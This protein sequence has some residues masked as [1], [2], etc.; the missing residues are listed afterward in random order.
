[1]AT[2]QKL[3]LWA[4][5]DRFLSARD[6]IKSQSSM[7]S[8][9]RFFKCFFATQSSPPVRQR[10]AASLPHFQEYCRPNQVEDSK[11]HILV[12]VLPVKEVVRDTDEG[13]G[14]QGKCE[15]F[16]K[17][18]VERQT[19]TKVM[20]YVIYIMEDTSRT[21]AFNI[22]QYTAVSMH[23]FNVQKHQTLSWADLWDGVSTNL[24]HFTFALSKQINSTFEFP[25]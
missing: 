2:L 23:V 5:V 1:M 7:E 3:V 12:I 13:H 16:Q 25:E 6:W 4:G 17:S 18:K 10:S 20:S 11:Q 21:Y 24:L 19:L 9:S 8:S 14:H 22:A 15:I